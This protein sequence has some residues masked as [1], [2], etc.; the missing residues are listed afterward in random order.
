MIKRKD[1]F[2][3]ERALVLPQ[4]VVHEMEADP[5]AS[6]LHITDI[7]YYPKARHHFRER[8][9]PITQYVFI[10]CTEGAGWFRIGGKTFPVGP[11]QYFILPA[12]QPHAY[13]ADE[14]N[15][16]TIYWIHFK[17]AT[18]CPFCTALRLSGRN[19][20]GGSFT[21]QRPHPSV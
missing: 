21:H 10:Y 17:G 18:G 4:P 3:G 2:C 13:K 19:Q 15:P 6:L 16:W 20:A 14:Q 9:S 5:V 12:G 1:G 7:G 8:K 11:D